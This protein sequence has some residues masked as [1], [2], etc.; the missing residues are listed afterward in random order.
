M[1]RRRHSAGLPPLE[2]SK[3]TREGCGVAAMGS[4]LCSNLRWYD[5]MEAGVE[6]PGHS[7]SD[8]IHTNT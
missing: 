2:R 1:H 5:E 8:A 3:A 4:R 6:K 7:D